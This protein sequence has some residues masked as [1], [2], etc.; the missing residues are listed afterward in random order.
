MCLSVFATSRGFKITRAPHARA[1]IASPSGAFLGSPPRTHKSPRAWPRAAHSSPRRAQLPNG[2]ASAAATGALA[3]QSAPP[4]TSP[5]RR[6]PDLWSRMRIQTTPLA[7]PHSASLSD[8]GEASDADRHCRRKVPSGARSAA[9][10]KS[11]ARALFKSTV[12][13]YHRVSRA[14]R[15]FSRSSTRACADTPVELDEFWRVV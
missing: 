11:A 15:T 1:K 5:R 4:I 6:A 14:A 2:A 12:A 10:K 7:M 8:C 3:G 13:M 9:T